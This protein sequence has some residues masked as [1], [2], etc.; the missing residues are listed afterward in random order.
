MRQSNIISASEPD[1]ERILMM[2]TLAF[3]ANPV[4]RWIFTE[5]KQYM[6]SWPLMIDAFGGKAFENGTAYM[7]EQTEGAILWLPPGVHQDIDHIVNLFEQTVHPDL[8]GEIAVM[9]EQMEAY[10]PKE[11]H[12]YLALAGVDPRY[13]GQGVGGALLKHSLKEVDE[14]G[15]IAYLESSDSLNISLYERHGF[16]VIGKTETDD[17]PPQFAMLRKPH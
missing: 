6:E 11:E 9:V 2:M 7:S 17:I 16:E 13:W 8:L 3:S 1:R 14:Q 12:W 5:A 15:I 10:H 4:A